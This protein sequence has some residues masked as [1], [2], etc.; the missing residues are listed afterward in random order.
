M[1]RSPRASTPSKAV[2]V[3]AVAIATIALGTAAI[4]VAAGSARAQGGGILFTDSGRGGTD[5]Y[6]VQADGSGRSALTRSPD[7]SEAQGDWSPF[8]DRIAATTW[9]GS[10]WR[11]GVTAPF[12]SSVEVV[13]GGPEDF[14]PDWSPSGDALLFTAYFNRDS[15]NQ[16]SFVMV[17]DPEGNDARP[18]IALQDPRYFLGNPTWSPDASRIAFTLASD[19]AG[20]SL[21]V[22]RPT[23]TDVRRLLEHP[24][25]DDIDPA[26]SPDGK[27][28][29]FASGR[30]AG[31]TAAT[32]HDIWL[33]DVAEGVAGTV[34]VDASR[35]LRRPSWSPDGQ[36][37]AFDMRT[38]T[39]PSTRYTIHV[40][41]SF[42]GAV[43]TP[44]T[45]GREP[46]WS[47]V[48]RPTATPISITPT[49]TT[50]VPTTATAAN[51]STPPEPSTVPPVPTVPPF[52]T[53]PTESPTDVGPAPTFPPPAATDTAAW[54]A[55]PE[56]PLATASP[57]DV[58][59]RHSAILPWAAHRGAIP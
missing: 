42:G 32:T 19:S 1:M 17:S 8:R 40:A 34:V 51:T 2:I 21:H 13:S 14:E 16:T 35:D 46:D 53:I 39:G 37:L 36:R 3:G 44:V 9:D 31:S 50:D 25:W 11:L 48:P 26:W 52:P 29:A 15:L 10:L 56:N 33:L 28:I 38:V 45:I 47:G 24:G 5:L 49:V 41:P 22:M 59:D 57:T 4:L 54:T 12:S 30:Y 23:G 27:R 20:G 18:V 6:V 55:T 58:T 7:L 43:G